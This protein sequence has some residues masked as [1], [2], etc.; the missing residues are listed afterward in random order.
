MLADDL[1]LDSDD[2]EAEEPPE[3]S[4]LKWNTIDGYISA[5]AELHSL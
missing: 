1:G 2:L 4:L 5:I 3:G